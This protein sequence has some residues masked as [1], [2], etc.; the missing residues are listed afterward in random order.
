MRTQGGAGDDD[1]SGGGAGGPPSGFHALSLD[2]GVDY[3]D[4]LSAAQLGLAWIAHDDY[5]DWMAR[6]VKKAWNRLRDQA[7]REGKVGRVIV[8]PGERGD[9]PE[10]AAID[11]NWGIPQHLENLRSE[12]L[13]VSQHPRARLSSQPT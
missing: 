9:W 11:L 4:F 13:A 7:Q 12:Q 8:T 10:F 5:K 2:F 6:G 3:V 1:P